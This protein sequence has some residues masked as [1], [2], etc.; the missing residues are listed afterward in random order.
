MVVISDPLQYAVFILTALATLC[1][2][3]SK[4]WIIS[5]ALFLPN[6][7]SSQFERADLNAMKPFSVNFGRSVFANE[8]IVSLSSRT[9]SD[10]SEA[11]DAD[12]DLNMISL[13]DSKSKTNLPNYL[14]L[15]TIPILFGSYTPV[16]KYMF[17]TSTVPPPPL[18]FNFLSYFVAFA[19]FQLVES[20]KNVFKRKHL[21][22]E[23]ERIGEV[24]KLNEN[25]PRISLLLRGG[26]ELGLWLF[27][28][29]LLLAIG[30]TG[31]TAT[32]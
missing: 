30:I 10:A 27:F 13:D 20:R 17:D 11:I 7:S 19:I 6:R 25:T 3:F 32:R 29:S 5:S 8:R 28:G 12:I 23:E 18:V 16:V 14:V 21:I 22:E 1:P 24:S 31:T 9:S 15:A 4:S 26:V 2:C